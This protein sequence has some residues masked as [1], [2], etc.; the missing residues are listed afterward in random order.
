MNNVLK[1][2]QV[3]EI[4]V[5]LKW[6]SIVGLPSIHS[7]L[8]SFFIITPQLFFGGVGV[9]NPPPIPI[10]FYNEQT[11]FILSLA[12]S[13]TKDLSKLPLFLQEFKFCEE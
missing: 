1:S 5:Y 2:N 10:I 3:Y 8:L 11:S 13:L 6:P 4:F 7:F 12:E 9:F